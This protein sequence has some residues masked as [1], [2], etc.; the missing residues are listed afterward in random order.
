[1]SSLTSLSAAM[2]FFLTLKKTPK[3]SRCQKLLFGNKH[4]H[5][6][7]R[8]SNAVSSAH[9]VAEEKGTWATECVWRWLFSFTCCCLCRL[10]CANCASVS[11]RSSSSILCCLWMS[12]VAPMPIR[13]SV[14]GSEDEKMGSRAQ[15]QNFAIQ[16]GT[17]STSCICNTWL[18]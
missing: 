10:E 6:T 1:M 9:S 16:L 3:N 8:E 11:C 4:A 5:R 12:T 17:Q 15:E 18:L 13:A 14:V 2:Y 7:A